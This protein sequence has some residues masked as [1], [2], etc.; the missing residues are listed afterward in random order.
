MGETVACNMGNQY[1]ITV[2]DE[3]DKILRELK[4]V[5]IKSSHAIDEAVKFLGVRAF[6]RLVAYRRQKVI[7]D[8]EYERA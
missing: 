3:S 4:D 2:S 6:A 1:S 5:N 7:R 8:E